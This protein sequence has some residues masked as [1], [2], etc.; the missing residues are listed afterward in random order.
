MVFFFELNVDKWCV[1]LCLGGATVA[2]P[3]R[4]FSP[5]FSFFTGGPCLYTRRR[6]LADGWW[7]GVTGV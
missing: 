5:L 7:Q 1:A 3:E 6:L 4:L 2:G